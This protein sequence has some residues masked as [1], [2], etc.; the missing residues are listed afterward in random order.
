MAFSFGLGYSS[1]KSFFADVAARWTKYP[2]S[3]YYPYDDYLYDDAGNV[4][5]SPVVYNTRNLFDIVM[6][7]GWRF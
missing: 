5:C 2:D 3:A 6:T 4:F 1:P 7:L